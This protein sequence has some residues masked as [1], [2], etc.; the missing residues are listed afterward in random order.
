MAAGSTFSVALNGNVAGT[1]GYSQLNVTGGAAVNLNNATLATT[2]GYAPLVTDTFTIINGGAIN[3]T[4]NGL[5]NNALVILGNF[6]GNQ[7]KA[8]IVYS[9]NMVQ[10]VSPVPEPGMILGLCAVVAGAGSVWRRRQRNGLGETVPTK[11]K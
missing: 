9:A 7:Y 5:P 4:F 2:V 8:T 6:N 11:C 3:G 1:S 10:L